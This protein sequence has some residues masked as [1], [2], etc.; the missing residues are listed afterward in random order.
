MEKFTCPY[1][2]TA[3]TFRYILC[4]K[5]IEQNK[6]DVNDMKQ[7]FVAMCEHQDWCKRIAN[8]KPFLTVDAEKCDIARKEPQEKCDEAAS[9]KA[10]TAKRKKK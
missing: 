7:C 4:A 2:K 1:A 3:K 10:K 5:K 6:T 8:C 9:E